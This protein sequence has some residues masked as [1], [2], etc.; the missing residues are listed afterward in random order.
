MATAKGSL[1]GKVVPVQDQ[2]EDQEVD[3]DG[4]EAEAFDDVRSSTGCRWTATTHLLWEHYNMDYWEGNEYMAFQGV[5][6]QDQLE[7]GQ[8]Q[9]LLC[10]NA[11]P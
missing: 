9:G 11:E 10:G 8:D 3:G 1:C 5:L 4:E 6:Q 2:V 7:G